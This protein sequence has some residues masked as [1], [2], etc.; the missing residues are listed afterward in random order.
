MKWEVF[1]GMLA[2]QQVYYLLSW[3]REEWE[4]E[5]KVAQAQRDLP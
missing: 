1:V 3:L 4:L 2:A 5:R